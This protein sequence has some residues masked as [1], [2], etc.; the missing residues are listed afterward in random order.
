MVLVNTKLRIVE[1]L[2]MNSAGEFIS[3][4]L[5]LNAFVLFTNWYLCKGKIFSMGSHLE[6]S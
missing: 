1:I 5:S 2:I 4:T 6:N 3:A